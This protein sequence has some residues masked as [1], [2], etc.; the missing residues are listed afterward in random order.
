MTVKEAIRH[1]CDAVTGQGSVFALPSDY[2]GNVGGLRKPRSQEELA[3]IL[4]QDNEKDW[5]DEMMS[6]AD[7]AV[8]GAVRSVEAALDSFGSDTRPATKAR[9]LRSYVLHR[10]HHGLPPEEF[11]ALDFPP[12]A[13]MPR[14]IREMGWRVED[15]LETC[16][17][18]FEMR[19]AEI[20]EKN[21]AL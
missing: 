16:L 13:M 5:L 18:R 10:F 3:L 15:F 14:T 17:E 19:V 4:A 8:I 2:S 20:L 1:W 21:E 12:D 9:L 7:V 6:T 11:R